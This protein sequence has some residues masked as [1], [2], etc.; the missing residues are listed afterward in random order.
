MP[1]NTVPMKHPTLAEHTAFQSTHKKYGDERP[2]LLNIIDSVRAFRLKPIP[3][4]TGNITNVLMF[5]SSFVGP[6]FVGPC[7]SV[8]RV[9]YGLPVE[10]F[11]LFVGIVY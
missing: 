7:L 1:V 8:N 11:T 2:S 5:C 10:C 4:H 6:A 9:K 3:C